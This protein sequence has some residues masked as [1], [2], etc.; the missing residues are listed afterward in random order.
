MPYV[1]VG[2]K[3]P[4]AT[5]MLIPA[6][7]RLVCEYVLLLYAGVDAP[8][9]VPV[10][11]K[12]G[13]G[14]RPGERGECMDELLPESAGCADEDG[15]ERGWPWEASFRRNSTNRLEKDCRVSSRLQAGGARGLQI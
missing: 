7:L 4:E 3:I 5:P 13:K 6:P 15:L 14:T 1:P 11:E 9:P 2:D 10:G 12:G 8:V